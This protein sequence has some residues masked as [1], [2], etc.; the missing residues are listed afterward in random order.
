[1]Y[2][3][4]K[5]PI[6]VPTKVDT[7]AKALLEDKKDTI[8][9]IKNVEDKIERNVMP[10]SLRMLINDSIGEPSESK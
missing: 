8:N 5:K 7:T 3:P 9:K 10:M 2:A 4:I 1:M 6:S